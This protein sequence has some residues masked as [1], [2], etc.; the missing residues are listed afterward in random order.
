VEQ[1]AITRANEESPVVAAFLGV[2]REVRAG[3]PG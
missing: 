1:A 3:S 2:A